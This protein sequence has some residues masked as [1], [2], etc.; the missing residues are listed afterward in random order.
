MH[1]ENLKL[2]DGMCLLCGTG[3]L[4]LVLKPV[5]MY[6]RKSLQDW[7]WLEIQGPVRTAQ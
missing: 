4:M 7:D 1:G 2:H 5:F 3:R 6:C